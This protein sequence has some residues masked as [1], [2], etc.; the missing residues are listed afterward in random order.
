LEEEVT[1][2]MKVT[3]L[4]LKKVNSYLKVMSHQKVNALFLNADE[5]RHNSLPF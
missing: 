3:S 4:D 5:A 1:A 2:L